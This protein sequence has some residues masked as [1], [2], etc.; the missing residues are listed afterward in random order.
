MHREHF[1][2]L[3][4]SFSTRLTK[5]GNSAGLNKQFVIVDNIVIQKNV[6]E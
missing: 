3:Q 5:L 2:F 1:W 6:K 4:K